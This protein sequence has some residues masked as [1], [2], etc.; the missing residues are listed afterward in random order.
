M[1]RLLAWV[2]LCFM[3]TGCCRTDLPP[4]ELTPVKSGAYTLSDGTVVDEWAQTLLGD[5][6]YRTGDGASLLRV[7]QRPAIESVYVVNMIRFDQLEETARNEIR[8]YYDENWPELD[9]L[10]ILEQAWAEYQQDTGESFSG[11][12][13]DQLIYPTA[14][15][16]HIVVYCVETM[17]PVED[18]VVRQEYTST[19]FDR[20]TGQVIDFWDLFTVDRE[21]AKDTMARLLAAKDPTVFAQEK[22]ED[23]LRQIRAGLNQERIRV[24][25]SGLEVCFPGGTL[26]WMKYDYYLYL[27]IDEVEEILYDWAVIPKTE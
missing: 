3:L 19:I 14:Y 13:A 22:G 10:A 5:R 12:R 23:Q 11:Y 26:S 2:L 15:N 18:N 27:R 17:V 24:T 6:V 25:Q 9:I 7:P 20:Q 21:T 8:V 16:D 1:R 4:E